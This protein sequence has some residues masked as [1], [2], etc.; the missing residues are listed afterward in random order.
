M[1]TNEYDPFNAETYAALCS[2]LELDGADSKRLQA[3]RVDMSAGIDDVVDDVSARILAEPSVAALV[4]DDPSGARTR[5]RLHQYL[6]HFFDGEYDENH[7]SSRVRLGRVHQKMGVQPAWFLASYSHLLSQLVRRQLTA[8]GVAPGTI[9]GTLSLLKVAMLDFSIVVETQEAISVARQQRMMN[10]F[11]T[12]VEEA[13]VAIVGQLMSMDETA[14]SQTQATQQQAS[15]VAEVTSSLSELR[16]TSVQ[17]R[18]QSEEMLE[19]AEKA[20]DA[21]RR[22]T[23]TVESSVVG[24]E[25]LRDRVEVIQQRICA[26]SDQ[27]RQIGDIIATVNEIAEQSKL[28]ALNASI[29]AARAGEFGRSFSVVANE[30]RDLAEQSKQ[31]TRQ[32]RELLGGIREATA[33]AVLATEEGIREVEVGQERARE[34]GVIVHELGDVVA[35]SAD[36]SR[37]I[38]NAARQQG[39][40]VSQVA[41]AMV[42]ID[43]ALRGG[44]GQTEQ[45]QQAIVELQSTVDGL[46]GQVSTFMLFGGADD[47]EEAWAAR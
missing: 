5:G 27:T 44:V 31:A 20:Q 33:E 29:E 38:A 26:L 15:A 42:E 11:S 4:A 32:V 36:S 16:M 8:A 23:Q 41:D 18:Q 9:D 28:L 21:A 10:E 22:G 14:E 24:M 1:S 3:M 46:L 43:G 12:M 37:L 17:A 35:Q 39:A 7:R 19:V 45:L 30:M 47:D 13:V 34:A 2:Y 25:A 40:G 6:D